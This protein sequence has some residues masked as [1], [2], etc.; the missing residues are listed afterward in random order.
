MSSWCG[1]GVVPEC[2]S[3]R[4][5]TGT[6][7][8]LPPPRRGVYGATLSARAMWCERGPPGRRSPTREAD[9]AGAR[10]SHNQT[11][12]PCRGGRRRGR[13]E[14]Y[15]RVAPREFRTQEPPPGTGLLT[16]L[17]SAE[18]HPRRAR[19]PGGGRWSFPRPRR[20]GQSVRSWQTRRQPGRV[21]EEERG[22]RRRSSG[23]PCL[24]RL[25]RGAR[26]GRIG[27]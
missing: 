1:T 3:N 7:S 11:H 13:P 15:Y 8:C 14:E 22:S 16:C 18:S 26:W 12:A 17:P 9:R 19:C 6:R 27:H 20:M 23:R 2:T 24:R 4:N 25:R 21:A 5:Q 10:G